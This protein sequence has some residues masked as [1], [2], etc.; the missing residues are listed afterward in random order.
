MAYT[1]STHKTL[2]HPLFLLKKYMNVCFGIYDVRN[3]CMCVCVC[4]YVCV[5]VCMC[6]CVCYN[7]WCKRKRLPEEC[8]W[9]VIIIMHISVLRF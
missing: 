4:V 1:I 7:G 2:Q 6:V 9:N 3:M 8:V 5:C